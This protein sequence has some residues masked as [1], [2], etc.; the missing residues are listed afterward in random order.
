MPRPSGRAQ[1]IAEKTIPGLNKNLRKSGYRS[2]KSK[3]N[4]DVEMKI[5]DINENRG[6]GK[7]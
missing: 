2:K 6:R 4:D 7:R 5:V 1:K 3:M